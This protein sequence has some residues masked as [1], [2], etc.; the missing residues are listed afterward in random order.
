MR[1]AH[2]K[3]MDADDAQD[4]YDLAGY[5]TTFGYMA[6][7]DQIATTDSTLVKVLR[8][9]G[10]VFYVK[11]TMPQTG[12]A[13]ETDSPLWGRTVNPF[14]TKLTPGGSSG[15][16]AALI[17]LRGSP[18][19]PATDIGGSIRAPAAFSGLYAIRPTSWRIPLSGMRSSATGQISIRVSCGPMCHS[20]ADLK[21]F[22]E[23]INAHPRAPHDYSSIPIRWRNVKKPTGKLAFG[24]WR[25]DGVVM[26]QPPILRALEETAAKL[27]SAGH[28][29]M[30]E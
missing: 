20:M 23:V 6:N 18:I 27:R 2:V 5:A 3:V 26:P 24:L 25:Y 13:L 29:G 17:A 19:G 16:E 22:T 21:M 8:D 15:G 12:M 4:T 11:T 28:E 10:A 9:A 1:L 7:K 30:V 14:N